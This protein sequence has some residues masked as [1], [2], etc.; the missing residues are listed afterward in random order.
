MKVKTLLLMSL[1]LLFFG[2]V[3]ANAQISNCVPCRSNTSAEY[4]QHNPWISDKL[5]ASQMETF[6]VIS[7]L[8][9][10]EQYN[11]SRLL[12]K[13]KAGWFQSGYRQGTFS[14]NDFKSQKGPFIE[15]ESFYDDHA[16]V[17]Q[18]FILKQPDPSQPDGLMVTPT[19]WMITKGHGNSR[20]VLAKGSVQ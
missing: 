16:G 10:A 14:L 18:Y 7:T 19:E 8:V 2:A 17:T 11:Y 9:S 3:T 1:L 5:M 6:P 15:W 4:L 12:S 13:G 20:T